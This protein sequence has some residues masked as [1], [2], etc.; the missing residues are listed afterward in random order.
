[1]ANLLKT[2]FKNCIIRKGISDVYVEANSGPVLRIIVNIR[3]NRNGIFHVSIETKIL[4]FG[5]IMEHSKI[6]Y[7][8]RIYQTFLLTQK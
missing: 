2:I 5:Q 8:E 3:F 4:I 1:M 7:I 6:V